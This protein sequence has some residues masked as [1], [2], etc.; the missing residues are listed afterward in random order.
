M[1]VPLETPD[2]AKESFRT[3]SDAQLGPVTD[4]TVTTGLRLAE[5]L[6]AVMSAM[7]SRVMLVVFPP[8][9]WK[10]MG[11][12]TSPLGT[13]RVTFVPDSVATALITVNRIIV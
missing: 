3:G 2:R 10:W 6:I 7:M 9:T 1:R 13:V 4:L 11:T 12:F 8:E 5:A